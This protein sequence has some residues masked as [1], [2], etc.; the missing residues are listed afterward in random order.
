MSS[1]KND[2][3]LHDAGRAVIA[4]LSQRR[5][6]EDADELRLFFE[7]LSALRAAVVGDGSQPTRPNPLDAFLSF[8]EIRNKTHGHGT[9]GAAFWA[10]NAAVL[11]PAAR[12]LA[13]ATPLW[14]LNLLYGLWL[15]IATRLSDPRRRRPVAIP[16]RGPRTPTS[17]HYSSNKTDASRRCRPLLRPTPGHTRSIWRMAPG[18]MPTRRPTSS[19]MPSKAL[20][21]PTVM[22]HFRWTCMRYFLRSP[23]AKPRASTLSRKPAACSIACRHHQTPM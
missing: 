19:P 15:A 6:R 17:A 11:D 1:L 14:R 4:W 10:K 20:R 22:S 7:P 21:P 2:D 9:Y 12:W 3:P 23:P 16:D 5:A 8:L 13:R 18:A